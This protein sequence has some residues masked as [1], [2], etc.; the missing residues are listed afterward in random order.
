[1]K[2]YKKIATVI[3]LIGICAVSSATYANSKGAVIDKNG[4]FVRSKLSGECV[5]T[6][7][8]VGTDVCAVNQDVADYSY[9]A[10]V[11]ATKNKEP[12]AYTQEHRRS[13]MVFFDFDKANLTASAQDVVS[14]IYSYSDDAKA[15]LFKLT[16]HADRAGASAY[17]LKLSEK[18]AQSVKNEL[19]KLGVASSN[20]SLSWKGEND[21]LVQTEDGIKEPQNRR[22]EI[23]VIKE[24]VEKN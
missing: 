5:R 8:D 18:R 4:N 20:I 24:T 6:K 16:G 15:V 19:V 10:P 9:K 13:Y 22:T 12:R 21:P 14:D 3:T 2:A 1:M 17:N 23:R 7:W 11:P